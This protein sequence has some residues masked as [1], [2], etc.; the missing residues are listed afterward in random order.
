MRAGGGSNCADNM[1]ASCRLRS[2]ILPAEPFR[3][4]RR[5]NYS[6]CLGKTS[7]CGHHS[8]QC[9]RLVT[10]NPENSS[11]KC[12]LLDCDGALSKSLWG[13]SQIR[14]QVSWL[15]VLYV[16]KYGK[17]CVPHNLDGI[18]VLLR[19]RI[20]GGHLIVRLPPDTD[21]ARGPKEFGLA[22]GFSTIILK[23]MR[24]YQADR[25]ERPG[26]QS[27]RASMSSIN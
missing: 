5:G 18:T 19:W 4:K 23:E 13:S 3:P 24:R 15:G 26:R 25:S 16:Q 2:R 17:L 8:L 21:S 14:T 20:N 1:S 7:A 27:R 9:G 11:R 22:V 10:I 6:R 12:P